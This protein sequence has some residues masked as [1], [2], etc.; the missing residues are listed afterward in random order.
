MRRLAYF[1]LSLSLFLVSSLAF[2]ENAEVQELLDVLNPIRSLQADFVQ[3][4]VDAKGKS[5]QKSE[6]KVVLQ[7]PGQF[8]W[9]VVR[10]IPQLIIADSHRIWIYDPDLEQVVVRP[11]AKEIGKTPAF[12]LSNVNTAIS[13]DFSVH[14]MQSPDAWL[15]FALKPKT[16]DSL[17]TVIQL[18][19][20]NKEIKEM[21][22]QDNLGHKTVIQFRHVKQNLTVSASVFKFRVPSNV[23]VI[24]ETR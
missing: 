17:F 16:K 15:W 1:F 23:D 21:R 5:V 11:V 4:I 14:K 19:F 2:A 18:G 8:R 22:M 13:K 10:P 3:T 20:M 6:G 9:D 24:D 12:L 7:R